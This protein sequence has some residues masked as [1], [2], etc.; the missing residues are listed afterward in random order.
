MVNLVQ[1]LGLQTHLLLL[2]WPVQYLEVVLLA[3]F[4][5]LLSICRAL[6]GRGPCTTILALVTD[7]CPT[8]PVL[9]V[10]PDGIKVSGLLILFSMLLFAHCT[11]TLCSQ[12][13]THLLVAS[14]MF[15]RVVTSLNISSVMSSSFSPPRTALLTIYQALCIHTELLLFTVYPFSPGQTHCFFYAFFWYCNENLVWLWCGLNLLLSTE[16]CAFVALH[17]LFPPV[18]KFPWA[19][20]PS[21][22][23]NSL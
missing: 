12:F 16:N 5:L 20:G 13:N 15:S 18:W 4:S 10:L 1:H 9:H 2:Q 22:L 17:F 14:S 21:N 23:A 7:W 6:M 8:H 3:T 19:T 11:S